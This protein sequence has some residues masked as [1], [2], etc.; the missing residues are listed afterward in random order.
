MQLSSTENV[1]L[2]GSVAVNGTK[3]WCVVY[4]LHE[5]CNKDLSPSVTVLLPLFDRLR[6]TL[7]NSYGAIR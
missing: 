2:S 6:V 4:L 7:V 3:R 1:Q 5:R